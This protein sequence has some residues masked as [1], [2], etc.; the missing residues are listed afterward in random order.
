MIKIAIT[1]PESTGKSTLCELL[2]KEYNTTFVPEFARGYI[3]K[4][5]RP[6][7]YND[8][9][10]IA[11]GQVSTE[12]QLVKSANKIIFCDTDLTVIKI[13]SEHKFGECHPW[14]L[15]K[16]NIIHYDYYFLCDIDIPWEFDE[17][18]EH[19][20]L[21]KYFFDLYK[22]EMESRNLP[23]QIISGKV[24]ERLDSCKK[25]LKNFFAT[26]LA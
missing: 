16:L 13:W 9:L 23:Y 18:R 25:I 10:E 3:E 1:G 19:P 15:N 4:L 20:Q 22:K 11:K 26:Q 8:L 24:N 2:A 5:D 12:S 14:I 17:Q 21:R 6:Y 7:H